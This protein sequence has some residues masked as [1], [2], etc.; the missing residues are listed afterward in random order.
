[1]AD[2]SWFVQ[3]DGADLGPLTPS[4]IKALVDEGRIS[5]ETPVK[6]SNMTA[7][8]PAKQ[9]RGLLPAVTS[10]P[11]AASPNRA[12]P[13]ARRQ[14][15]PIPP[16]IIA[17]VLASVVGLFFIL[18]LAVGLGGGGNN[19]VGQQSVLR[20]DLPPVNGVEDWMEFQISESSTPPT[21]MI[22]TSQG[23][24]HQ[25]FDEP[26]AQ[27]GPRYERAFFNEAGFRYESLMTIRFPDVMPDASV[28][29]TLQIEIDSGSVTYDVTAK[30]GQSNPKN[31]IH[32]KGHIV[33]PPKSAFLIGHKKYLATQGTRKPAASSSVASEAT[34]GVQKT[35][36]STSSDEAMI[37]AL[38][39]EGE[40]IKS[41]L[42]EVSAIT[43]VSLSLLRTPAF[44]VKDTIR[45][46][47]E[48]WKHESRLMDFH[49]KCMA[50][51]ALKR[52]SAAR[53]A[54]IE[55]KRAA[56]KQ[57]MEEASAKRDADY[58]AEQERI[59]KSDSERE[60]QAKLSR[61]AEVNKQK[62]KQASEDAV[63]AGKNAI[64]DYKIL[65]DEA[66]V[67]GTNT[68]GYQKSYREGLVQYKA[69]PS[70]HNAHYLEVVAG[71]I[72]D[73]ELLYQTLSTKLTEAHAAAMKANE[74][75]VRAGNQPLTVPELPPRPS[76]A[77]EAVPA[78][79]T[80]KKR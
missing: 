10:Q 24:W 74:A 65:L 22:R 5:A 79:G 34:P 52:R 26:T 46:A 42:Q 15:P 69:D 1:M 29:Q 16:K 45:Q 7:F 33:I 49:A 20:V 41:D 67:I 51:E 39:A 18:V 30:G 38:E 56:E 28:T 13:V 66:G 14:T 59:R 11:Q 8:V 9:V 54:E 80:K 27:D 3:L 64:S 73:Q 72:R 78:A 31:D 32:H 53:S 4:D 6:R 12:R 70:Q 21:F 75:S 57:A 25:P 60:A 40:K 48:L 77:V 2:A 47:P 44:L 76:F 19:T 35:S 55:V 63:R 17:L 37:K 50:S 36:G 23:D 61:E 62:D 68:D 58:K 43:A 71:Q